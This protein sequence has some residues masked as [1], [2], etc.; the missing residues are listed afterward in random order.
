MDFKKIFSPPF[1][2]DPGGY[3]IYIWCKENKMAFNLLKSEVGQRICDLLNGDSAI[4]FNNIRVSEDNQYILDGYSP[5]L[6]V[7]GWGR[8]TGAM[9]LDPSEA[10][11]IQ[12]EFVNWAAEM[13]QRKL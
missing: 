10:I 11:R 5:L 1:H 2:P 13:L 12:N 4:P 8:L 3:Q 7:R 6:K 9:K